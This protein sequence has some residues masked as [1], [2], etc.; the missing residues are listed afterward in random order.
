MADEDVAKIVRLLEEIRDNQRLQLERQS[1]VLVLQRRSMDKADAGIA[2]AR[3]LQDRA[4]RIQE[5]SHSLLKAGRAFFYT[6]LAI[7]GVL[8][9]L[10]AWITFE[11]R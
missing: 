6:V 4:E 1:E 8:L 5:R 11:T 2:D 7:V 10:V 3:N 9:A